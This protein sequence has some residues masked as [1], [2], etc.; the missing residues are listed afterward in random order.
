MSVCHIIMLTCNIIMITC[1]MIMLICDLNYVAC[2]L[3]LIKYEPHSIYS[4]MRLINPI[5]FHRQSVINL[6]SVLFS[7]T[8]N[9]VGHILE[10]MI[11]ILARYEFSYV[12]CRNIYGRQVSCL[13]QWKTRHFSPRENEKLCW[14]LTKI[15]RM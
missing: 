2:Q 4:S 15:S 14:L 12:G 7:R 13:N 6:I 11:K 3:F 10:V 1:K 8:K 9:F 5:Y